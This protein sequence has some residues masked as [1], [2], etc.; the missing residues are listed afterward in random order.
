MV[1][2]SFQIAAASSHQ[3]MI[4]VIIGKLF[5]ICPKVDMLSKTYKDCYKATEVQSVDELVT[6][7]K[8]Y[9][10]PC[11]YMPQKPIKRRYKV[12]IL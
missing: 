3:Q 11:Q 9:S 12:C 4:R 6:G 1:P 10:S 7:C 5:K 8:G 2:Q